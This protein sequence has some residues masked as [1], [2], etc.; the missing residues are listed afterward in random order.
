MPCLTTTSTT[1]ITLSAIEKQLFC[2]ILSIHEKDATPAGFPQ[3]RSERT[4]YRHGIAETTSRWQAPCWPCRVGEDP[5]LPRPLP[6]TALD[7]CEIQ[8]NPKRPLVRTEFLRRTA[9]P[10]YLFH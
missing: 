7:S 4:S 8:Q 3:R 9:S 5:W 1:S 6:S 2:G 10:Y